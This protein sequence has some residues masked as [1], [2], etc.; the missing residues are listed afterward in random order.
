MS[1]IRQL[2]Y[3]TVPSGKSELAYREMAL[4]M[5]VEGE[6]AVTTD[7]NNLESSVLRYFPQITHLTIR[8]GGKKC[9]LDGLPPLIQDLCLLEVRVDTFDNLQSLSDL[10][11]FDYRLG[12]IRQADGLGRCT[13]LQ[14][15]H[16]RRVEG[17]NNLEFL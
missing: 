2:K 14:V 13:A 15:L 10:R 16:F 12:S 4:A 7:S 8:G 1:I 11:V 5:Q 17:L 9:R 3:R 6:S